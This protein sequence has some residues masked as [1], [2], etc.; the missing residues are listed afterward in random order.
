MILVIQKSKID[1]MY[2]INWKFKII[3][4]LKQKKN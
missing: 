1:L 3:F 2:K 4:V